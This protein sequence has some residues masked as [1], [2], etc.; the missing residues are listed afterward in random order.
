MPRVKIENLREGMVVA[1]EVKNMEDMLLLPVGCE[2]RPKH[3]EILQCWGITDVDVEAFDGLEEPE[4]PIELLPP[5]VAAR[6]ET[7]LRK[8]FWNFN[9]N[10]LVQKEVFRLALKRKAK[11]YKQQ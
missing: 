3:I 6:L 4:N 7:E 11:L 10:N 5:K 2:I 9:P 8:R 1:K